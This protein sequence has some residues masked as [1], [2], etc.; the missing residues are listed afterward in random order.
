MAITEHAIDADAGPPVYAEAPAGMRH[1]LFT[2][3]EYLRLGEVGVIHPEE[4]V[5][6]LE[7]EIVPMSLIG[8]RHAV[9]TS[10][11]AS[12]FAILFQ[13]RKEVLVIGQGPA[14]LS[15]H[16]MPQ[17]DVAIVNARIARGAVRYPEVDDVYLLI[18]V[19]ETTLRQDLG[20]KRTLYAKAGIREYWVVD[21]ESGRVIVHRSPDRE[22][23]AY[24]EVRE[25]Q[26]DEALTPIAWPD[27]TIRVADLIPP[28]T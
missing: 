7:G 8:P 3:G 12:F 16:S 1:R 21:P 27:V 11:I 17:P 5:E 14:R 25:P 4:R 10:M 18:E 2:V 26:G 20:A 15:L 24:G 19:S 23:G 28:A 6:L 9:I 13:N 22:K